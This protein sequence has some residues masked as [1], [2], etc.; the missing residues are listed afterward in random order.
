MH[1]N[2]TKWIAAGAAVVVTAGI[3]WATPNPTG[4]VFNPL[5]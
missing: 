5:S 3:V 4:I 2:A 1:R